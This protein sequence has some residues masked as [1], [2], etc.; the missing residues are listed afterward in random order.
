VVDVSN[1]GNQDAADVVVKIQIDENVKFLA[2]SVVTSTGLVRSGN[3]VNDQGPIVVRLGKLR[4]LKQSTL[5][6]SAVVMSPFNDMASDVRFKVQIE[7]SNG[8]SVSQTFPFEVDA[9]A[10]I[11]INSTCDFCV[12]TGDV[13]SSLKPDEMIQVSAIIYN[14][15]NQNAFNLVFLA[16][17][18]SPMV[19]S[20]APF[21]VSPST[22]SFTYINHPN[23]SL[24]VHI[25]MLSGDG[26]SV[27]FSYYLKMTADSSSSGG[28]SQSI[29][30]WTNDN[31]HTS[32]VK[33]CSSTAQ[34]GSSRTQLMKQASTCPPTFTPCQSGGFSPNSVASCGTVTAQVLESGSSLTGYAATTGDV[35]QITATVYVQSSCLDLT[36]VT[37]TNIPDPINTQLI[38]GSVRPSFGR[39][40]SG[41]TKNDGIV[42]IDFGVVPGN[43]QTQSI[44]TFQVL[45]TGYI[46]SDTELTNSG[47]LTLSSYGTTYVS[48]IEPSVLLMKTT[49]YSSSGRL[50]SSVLM[51]LCVLSALFLWL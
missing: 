25:P 30:V 14:I 51:M 46:K 8:K 11:T 4:S 1:S 28:I 9:Y 27:S 38:V 18:S 15:G 26:G 32:I 29:D 23:G 5:K 31:T 44:I 22:T 2:G 19:A 43:Q 35:I 37:F 21:H 12:S 49:E 10:Q 13:C 47:F 16:S 39:V 7:S 48:D 3:Y 20:G 33:S 42:V 36:G 6:F 24:E 41:N 17:P 50:V 45:V 34:Q 40:V